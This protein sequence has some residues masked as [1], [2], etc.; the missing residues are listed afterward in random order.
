M[1]K[2]FNYTSQVRAR[3][4]KLSVH[5]HMTHVV[6]I[7]NLTDHEEIGNL[8]FPEIIFHCIFIEKPRI[9]SKCVQLIMKVQHIV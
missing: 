7:D 5:Y 4:R 3:L 6:K 8:H 2:K 9:I 1:G